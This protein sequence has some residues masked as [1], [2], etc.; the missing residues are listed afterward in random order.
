MNA[1]FEHLTIDLG[2]VKIHAAV[3]KEPVSRVAAHSLHPVRACAL[4]RETAIQSLA[5]KRA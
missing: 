5:A 2:E 3:V 4:I 1:G